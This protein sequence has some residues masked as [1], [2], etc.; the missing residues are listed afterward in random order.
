MINKVILLGDI[1]AAPII[2]HTLEGEKIVC[3]KIMTYHQRSD[4]KGV[5]HF[6]HNVRIYEKGLVDIVIRN[7][8]NID[9]TVYIEG[10]L[11]TFTANKKSITCVVV[12][13]KND[14]FQLLRQVKQIKHFNEKD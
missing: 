10:S 4:K 2:K 12:K 5:V 7:D 1:S 3:F 8:L 6:Y 13:G 11:E 14:I 9:D